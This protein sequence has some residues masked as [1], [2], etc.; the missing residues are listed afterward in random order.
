VL[1]AHERLAQLQRLFH[2]AWL[3]DPRQQTIQEIRLPS[4]AASHRSLLRAEAD[5][6]LDGGDV[7]PGF[8]LPVAAVFE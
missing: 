1:F 5:H 7:V 4:P 3:V 8:R 6:A 2:D